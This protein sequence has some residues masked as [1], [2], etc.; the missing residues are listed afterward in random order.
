VFAPE[1]GTAN[2]SDMSPGQSNE[3]ESAMGGEQ[4]AALAAWSDSNR[5]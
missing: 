1:T 2:L 3:S 4:G 5:K